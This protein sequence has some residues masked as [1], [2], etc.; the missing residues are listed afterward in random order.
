MTAAAKW[1]G[2]PMLGFD[3]ETTGID[4]HHD[5][6]VTA[7]LVECHPGQRPTITSYVVDPGTEISPE[8]TAV[9][10]YTRDRAAAEATHTPEQMLFEVTGRLAL[11]M[12]HGYPIVGFNVSFDLTLLEAENQRHQVDTLA[13]RGSIQP[14]VDVYVLDKFADPYRK[15]G[16]KLD[17]VCATYG[18]VHTGAHDAG[19]DAL[20]ACR[21]WPRLMAKHARKF[22][23]MTLPA[24]HQ[25]QVGW[26]RTQMDGLRAYFDKQGTVH[27]GCDGGW[28]IHD[29]ARTASAVAS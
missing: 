16:R 26:R 1:A 21:L 28:P 3:T 18:V 15:G 24:L 14:V 19:G 6:I 4:V 25:S 12:G 22:P 10:G 23:G 2:F 7:A 20:A 29:S 8:A 17:Q 5:R 13:A 9:H 27:D 11:W